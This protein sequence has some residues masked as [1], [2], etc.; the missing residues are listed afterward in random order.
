MGLGGGGRCTVKFRRAARGGGE[1]RGVV[2]SRFKAMRP[3]RPGPTA[4]AGRPEGHAVSSRTE[5]D[6]DATAQ[7]A[8]R[9]GPRLLPAQPTGG[10]AG[11]ALGR[12]WRPA[13]IPLATDR[14]S[15]AARRP[16]HPGILDWNRGLIRRRLTA[17]VRCPEAAGALVMLTQPHAKSCARARARGSHAP[18]YR[19]P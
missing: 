10:A 15:A 19:R 16:C 14:R 6:S 7:L 11:T 1:A 17:V 8:P 18:D 3:G 9:A 4:A 13:R 12:D 2:G 5:S